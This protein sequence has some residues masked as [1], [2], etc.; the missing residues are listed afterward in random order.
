MYTERTG[1][2]RLRKRTVVTGA[3]RVGG[4]LAFRS[5]PEGNKMCSTRSAEQR[6]ARTKK[7][8]KEKSMLL[9]MIRIVE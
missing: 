8:K 5:L 6:V 2:K 1:E 4:S 9:G 3:R 7:L